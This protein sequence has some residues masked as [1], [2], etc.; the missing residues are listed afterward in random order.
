MGKHFNKSVVKTKEDDKNFESSTKCWIWDNAFV[1]GDVKVRDWNGTGIYRGAAH[2]YCNI[3][4]SLNY[5]IPIVFDNLK[6]YDSHLIMQELGKFNFKIS[7]ISNRL[8]KYMSFILNNNL[9]FI[10]R[11]QFLSSSLESLVK[12]LG[13]NGFK[14]LNQ[15]FDGEA[16]HL[17]KQTKFCPREYM[18]SFEKFNKPLPINIKFYSSLIGKGIDKERQHLLRLWNKFEM[19][20]MK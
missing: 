11:F 3:N 1:K 20:T 16:L 17:V 9:V 19:K 14:Y 2:R 5:K 13:K 6:N 7:V 4:V 8:E 10:D 12:N 15:E 18:S